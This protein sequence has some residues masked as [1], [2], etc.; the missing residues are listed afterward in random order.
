M[1][2]KS[3]V[4]ESYTMSH[5]IRFWSQLSLLINA[6][7]ILLEHTR[8]ESKNIQSPAI[9]TSIT[10]VNAAL[11]KGCGDNSKPKDIYSLKAP[12]RTVTNEI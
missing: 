5:Y 7:A 1:R 10:M 3:T 9:N 12:T 11:I 2:T 6:V 8:A 4:Q